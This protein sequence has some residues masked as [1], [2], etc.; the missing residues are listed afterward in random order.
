MIYGDILGEHHYK[1]KIKEKQGP[2]NRNASEVFGH[3]KKDGVTGTQWARGTLRGDK[4]REV[5][6]DLIMQNVKRH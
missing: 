1:Q 4:V 2:K 6:E 5:T 3:S